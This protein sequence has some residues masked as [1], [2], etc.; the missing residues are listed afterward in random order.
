MQRRQLQQRR[1]R[2]LPQL[3]A[4]VQRRQLL[5][6]QQVRDPSRQATDREPRSPSPPLEAAA[7]AAADRRLVVQRYRLAVVAHLAQ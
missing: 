5:H 2:R 3:A 6:R 1:Q 7:A 4:H